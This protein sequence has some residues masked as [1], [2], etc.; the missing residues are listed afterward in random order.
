MKQ[1]KFN[2]ALLPDARNEYTA[3]KPTPSELAALLA[4]AHVVT[5]QISARYAPQAV[6]V[7]DAA[8]NVAAETNQP[9]S[10]RPPGAGHLLVLWDDKP[11]MVVHSM[12]AGQR[13]PRTEFAGGCSPWPLPA[14]LLAFSKNGK[15]TEPDKQRLPADVR[16]LHLSALDGKS[17][18]QENTRY[19]PETWSRYQ[20]LKKLA[21]KE[22]LP[23]Q[24][25]LVQ[26]FDE[27]W[28][29]FSRLLEDWPHTRERDARTDAA[30]MFGVRLEL[31]DDHLLVVNQATNETIGKLGV[32]DQ[33]VVLG[34]QGTV[35]RIEQG[36][37]AARQ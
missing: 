15:A 12:P 18:K 34:H 28:Y 16:G 1:M 30:V 21:F 22:E 8:G 23:K 19:S 24:P 25:S 37:A 13:E 35:L 9:A 17:A 4:G 3:W 14:E 31:G 6:V 29:T 26:Q 27:S 36:D 33:L 7:V 5:I 11:P 10:Y 32:G 20:N 2:P